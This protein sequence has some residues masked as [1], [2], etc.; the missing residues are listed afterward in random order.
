MSTSITNIRTKIRAILNEGSVA[1]RDPFTF[2]SSRTFT[3]SEENVI[4]IVAV[5]VND[6]EVAQSGGTWEYNEDTNKV[7]FDD[8]Y[9]FTS[10]DI[11]QVDYTSYKNYSNNEIEGFIRGSMAY[12]SIHGYKTF[13]LNDDDINPIPEEAEENLIAVVAT[14]L[15]KPDNKTIRLPDLAITVPIATMPTDDMIRKVIAS[16]KRNSHGITGLINTKKC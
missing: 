1:Q 4:S 9:S 15:I 3:L 5:Y 2:E 8:S 7:I 14:I 6:V 16:F 10:G 13:E 12:V 11:I